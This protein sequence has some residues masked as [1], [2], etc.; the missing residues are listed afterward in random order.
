VENHDMSPVAHDYAGELE[1]ES[2][3][4]ENRELTHEEIWDDSALIKAWDAAIDEYKAFHGSESEWKT[5][6]PSRPSPLW[7]NIPPSPSTTGAGLGPKPLSLMHEKEEGHTT[8]VL[9]HNSVPLNFNTFVPSHDPALPSLATTDTQNLTDMPQ[10]EAFR[11]ALN[12][13]YWTGYWTAVYH[14]RNAP[15]QS[16]SEE[17]DDVESGK[18]EPESPGVG[19]TTDEFVVSQ[20]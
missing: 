16:I 5:E 2:V 12:A 4:V 10:D 7:H 18:D 14:C 6:P 17:M 13:M 19:G 1:G 15:D 20:R 11:N 9:G 8:P 3:E